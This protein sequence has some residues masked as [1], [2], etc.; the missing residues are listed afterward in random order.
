MTV[1]LSVALRVAA[2]SVHKLYSKLLK[3]DYVGECNRGYEEGY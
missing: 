2:A 3:G 1:S